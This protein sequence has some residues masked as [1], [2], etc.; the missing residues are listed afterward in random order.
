MQKIEFKILSE[1]GKTQIHCVNYRPDADKEIVGVI[2]IAHGVTEYIGRY[3]GIAK[4]FTDNGYAVF[5]HDCLGHGRSF[6]KELH[7]GWHNMV[8]DLNAC[9]VIAR[10]LHPDV[11]ICMLGFSMGSLLVRHYLARYPNTIEAAVL[12]GT[13]MSN[14]IIL[15]IG[16]LIAKLEGIRVGESNSTKLIKKMMF[17]SYNSY[18]ATPRTDFD[19]LCANPFA[20]D[21][22]IHDPMCYKDV[23]CSLSYELLKGM[24]IVCSKRIIAKTD[25]NVPILLVSGKNDPVGNCDKGVEKLEQMLRNVAKCKEVTS[26]MFDGRHDVLRDIDGEAALNWICKWFYGVVVRPSQV[27]RY[28]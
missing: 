23:W 12:V 11:P 25:A 15:R 5:G 8:E 14:P 1:D 9:R 22:Y 2:Q 6:T 18:I 28:D 4:C 27:K 26:S 17:G 19:W 24:S 13:G 10:N 3:E 7:N 16:M 21:K 20:V